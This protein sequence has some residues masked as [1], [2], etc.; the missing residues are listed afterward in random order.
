MDKRV[1]AIVLLTAVLIYEIVQLEDVSG[2]LRFVVALLILFVAGE[3]LGRLTH[4]GAGWGL[5]LW[6]T[7]RGIE[8]VKRLARR[9]RFWKFFADVGLG[10][11]FGLLSYFIIDRD[12]RGKLGV[13]LTSFVLLTLLVFIVS[14]L[15]FPYLSISL[16]MPVGA[17]KTAHTESLLGTLA[18]VSLVYIGG[19]ALFITGGLVVYGASV[20][21]AMASSVL[22]G[23][24]AIENIEEGVM[25]LLPGINL[26]FAEGILA[27]F[28][29]LVVHEGAHA[30][31]AAIGRIPILSSGIAFFGIIPVGAFVEPDEN[32]LVKKP[33][34]LQNRVMVAGSAS[35]LM[36]SIVFFLLLTGF[37]FLTDD[38]KDR[39]WLVV[40]GM[41]NGTIIYAIND[42]PVEEVE[43]LEVEPGDAIYLETNRGV[44]E[45]TVGEDG[46]IGIYYISL[47]W[48]PYTSY[49]NPALT[50]IFKTLALS[51]CLNF[52]V[53]VVNLLPLP[54]FDG[55]RLAELNI[56][57]ER[58]TKAIM[59]VVLI[60]FAMN[61]LPVFF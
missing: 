31:L 34:T 20:L 19:F 25:L 23:N 61:V 48:G 39:G 51:F 5:L 33:R 56:R 35:N 60:A 44:V 17:G 1:L 7:K 49:E 37:L 12:L 53:G 24:G 18:T 54:F 43:T 10:I 16:G 9:E 28:I 59:Y 46:K 38:F 6:R 15:V 27:L 40:D 22:F 45:R 3:M 13:L 36:F 52:V 14:P 21:Y 58:I 57:N 32:R 2:P 47:S 50:F 41:E 4:M 11:C 29:I 42:V 55:Y 8:L 30:I 26:P